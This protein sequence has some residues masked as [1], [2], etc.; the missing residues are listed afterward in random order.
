[1]WLAAVGTHPSSLQIF[2]YLLRDHKILYACQQRFALCQTHAQRF[3]CQLP[4]LN[5]QHAPALPA[6]VS[7]YAND[8]H[9]DIH[10]RNL[11]S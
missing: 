3:Y 4:P 7:V 8:L 2:A 5:R 11:Q 6:A 1:V 10:G 9:S